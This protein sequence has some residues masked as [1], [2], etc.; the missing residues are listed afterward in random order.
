MALILVLSLPRSALALQPHGPPEGFYV[1]QMAHILFVVAMIFLLYH[2][3]KEQIPGLRWFTFGGILFILWNFNTLV[4]H[5]SE[6]YVEPQN[7]LGGAGH[8][9][10]RLIMS[11]PVSWIYYFTKL[12]NLI[13]LPAFI[14]LFF[15]LQAMARAPRP[16]GQR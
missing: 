1:H 10:R 9:S 8:F 3:R 2:L 16:P 7:F 11:G 6:I 13:L 14:L 5:I 12:D 4:G 15:G